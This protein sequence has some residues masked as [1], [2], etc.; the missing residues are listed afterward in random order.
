V[1]L[2]LDVNY[3]KLLPLGVNVVADLSVD[4]QEGRKVWVKY[5]L[6]SLDG[7]TT[8]VEGTALFY[9]MPQLPGESI[10]M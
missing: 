1:T 10:F 4:K 6:R 8:H 7:K 2:N 3:R 9:Q 5:A